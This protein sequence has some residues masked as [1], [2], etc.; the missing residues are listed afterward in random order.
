MNKI[1]TI[2]GPAM[3][4]RLLVPTSSDPTIAEETSLFKRLIKGLA[5]KTNKNLEK[6]RNIV[7][8]VLSFG[9]TLQT[10]S[11]P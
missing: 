7:K 5:E 3:I 10:W 1:A 2:P 6:K 8:L 9:E 11:H 4:D